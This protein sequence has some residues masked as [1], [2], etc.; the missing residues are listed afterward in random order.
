MISFSFTLTN[1]FAKTIWKSLWARDRHLTEDLAYELQL[2]RSNSILDVYFEW[3]TNCDHS[4]VGLRLG[5][6]GYSLDMGIYSVH[7]KEE[8]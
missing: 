7:H 1:P 2:T 3:R 8:D 6:F 5:L 4:G